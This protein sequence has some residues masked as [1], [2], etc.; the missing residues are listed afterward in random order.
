MEVAK[1]L[2]FR[3]PILY[4][5]ALN[6]DFLG[7]VDAQ[8]AV[9]V[10]DGVKYSVHDGFKT[11]ILRDIYYTNSIDMTQDGEYI[12]SALPDSNE[13]ALFSLSKKEAVYKVSRHSG[14]IESVGIDPAGRYFIT[15]GQ[16]GKS[17]AWVLETSRLAFTLPDHSDFVSVVAFSKNSQ[18]IATGSYDNTINLL[19]IATLNTHI[20][21][22]GHSSPIVGIVFLSYTMILSVERDGAVIVWD[23][24]AQ[25]ILKRLES[26]K[27]EVTSIAIS[28]DDRF[29]F[30][31]TKLGYVGLYDTET[32]EQISHK[33]I[34]LTGSITSLATLENPFRLAVGTIDGFIYI[35]N[36][37]GDEAHLTEALKNQ[38]YKEIYSELDK[39]PMLYYS[40]IYEALE[41]IWDRTIAR[42]ERLLQRNRIKDAQA[43]FAPFFDVPKKSQIINQIFKSYEKYEQFIKLV[44]ENK[45]QLAYNMVNQ[46]PAFIHTEPY[47]QMEEGWKRVFFRA[48]ELIL[49]PNGDE[50]ARELL[51]PYRGISE[52]TALIQ[53][54]FNSQKTYLYLRKT[55][56]QKDYIKFF[57]L[58]KQYPFLKEF[59]EYQR[60]KDYSDNLYKK[61]MEAFESND[62]LSARK[63]CDELLLFPKYSSRAEELRDTI[64]IRYLFAEAIADKNLS[65]AYYYLSLFPLLQNIPEAIWL[66]KEWNK[67]VDIAQK[68]A[69]KGDVDNTFRVFKPYFAIKAK[70]TAMGS[71]MAQAYCARIEHAVS[72]NIDVSKITQA[73]KQY[74]AIF[75]DDDGI[76]AIIELFERLK[77][78]KIDMEH[79]RKGSL[80]SWS[81]QLFSGDF[82]I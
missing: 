5:R 56:S 39:N 9:R 28:S 81:P 19:N 64:R 60:L 14:E 4:L 6:N 17:Y 74:I 53:Q 41:Y 22:K 52:K 54:L 46:Y 82:I 7:S 31:G 26:M 77:G 3:Q 33:Y 67:S 27:D 76:V 55:L 49:T 20:K 34:K 42:A 32:M 1:S 35:Y 69:A 18:Y 50:K 15:C 70:F 68:Y 72:K 45:L 75:G 59:P 25:K 23:I 80:E 48:Q 12:V 40:K 24:G 29:V 21:F 73:I 30:I 44:K 37:F 11:N 51:A 2:Y 58:I 36:L 61:T 57:S 8:N 63:M 78:T 13:V 47:R 66:E 16:D 43:A 65:D 38:Y 79:L 62:Y 10:I 71:V